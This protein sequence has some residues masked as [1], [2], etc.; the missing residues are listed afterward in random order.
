MHSM[1]KKLISLA[2]LMGF[3]LG[4]HNGYIALWT[5][6][7]IEPDRVF[8]YR[9]S[10]LPPADQEALRKGIKADDIL[11]LTRLMEDYLS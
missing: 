3:I 1:K 10:T 6:N 7:R 11:E 2:L 4:S 8:P 9:V 5:D